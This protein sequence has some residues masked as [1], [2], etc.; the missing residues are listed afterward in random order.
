MG[1][2]EGRASAVRAGGTVAGRGDRS[3]TSFGEDSAGRRPFAKI[4]FPLEHVGGAKEW[5]WVATPVS[6]LSQI[7][8]LVSGLF[9]FPNLSHGNLVISSL[10]SDFPYP[11]LHSD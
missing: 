6:S 3:E 4:C 2:A 7:S 1:E 11:A 10:A 8:C 5:A 9:L